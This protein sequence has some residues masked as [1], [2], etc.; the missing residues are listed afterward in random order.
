LSARIASAFFSLSL[1]SH[2]KLPGS[3]SGVPRKRLTGG[4]PGSGLPQAVT[5]TVHDIFGSVQAG[6]G[7]GGCAVDTEVVVA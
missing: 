2:A 3:G 4:L 6:F 1:L 5:E 7:Y